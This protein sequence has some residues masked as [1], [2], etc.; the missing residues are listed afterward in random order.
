[1]RNGGKTHPNTG[2]TISRELGLL[3]Y[4]TSLGLG[5]PRA[6]SRWAEKELAEKIRIPYIA[7]D[8]GQAGLEQREGTGVFFVNVPQGYTGASI[9]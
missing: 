8:M 4:I 7:M 9:G 1:L 5:C 3:S 6:L 2:R